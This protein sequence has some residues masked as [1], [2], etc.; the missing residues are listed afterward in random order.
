MATSSFSLGAIIAWTSPSIPDLERTG[1]LGI[2]TLED[3]SWIASLVT[4]STQTMTF[5]FEDNFI[6]RFFVGPYVC[7]PLL[8][9][10]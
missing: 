9:S 3:K 8:I 6:M 4:V 1:S 2:L 10:R 5:L 7:L